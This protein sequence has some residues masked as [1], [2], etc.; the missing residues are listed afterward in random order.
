MFLIDLTR[1]Y[2]MGK[3]H[4]PGKKIQVLLMGEKQQNVGKIT[5]SKRLEKLTIVHSVFMC[6]KISPYIA[7]VSFVWYIRKTT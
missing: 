7:T 1:L 4:F 2:L 5:K 6:T 3:N